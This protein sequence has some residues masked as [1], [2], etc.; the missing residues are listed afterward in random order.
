MHVMNKLLRQIVI[1]KGGG[2]EE[3][4]QYGEVMENTSLLSNQFGEELMEGKQ[5]DNVEEKE[6]VKMVN[7]G[8]F[9]NDNSMFRKKI[10]VEWDDE[11]HEKF[12]NAVT[13][14]GEGRCYP[15]AILN[16]MNV[17]GLTRM[18]VAS[19]LQRCRNVNWL[20]R[21]KRKYIPSDHVEMVPLKN[22]SPRMK[23]MSFGSMPHAN[24]INLNEIITTC[25]PNHA[26]AH[27]HYNRGARELGDIF[28]MDDEHILY[29]EDG[30]DNMPH[31]YLNERDNAKDAVLFSELNSM[32]LYAMVGTSPHGQHGMDCNG[33]LETL[34]L[35]QLKHS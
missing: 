9:D 22:R 19:H 18:Q 20:S 33:T 5:S 11:L 32:T 16:L 21:N 4:K 15:R 29:S 14:L 31:I 6:L 2:V 12:I 1:Q 25:P 13:K 34:V 17:P 8:T 30:V 24:N 35:N 27:K 23:T 28:N 26:D 7:S 10:W 3:N